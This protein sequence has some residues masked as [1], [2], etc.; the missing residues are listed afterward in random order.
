M[1]DASL[2]S[3][4]NLE[5]LTKAGYTYIVGSRMHKIPY[6]IA[7]YQKTQELTDNQIITTPIE[8][9]QRVIYQYREKR[10]KLDMH[11]IEKQIAKAEKSLAVRLLSRRLSS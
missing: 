11:N 10:A 2:L 5:A 6:D 8:G 7:E 1:A 9:S 3:S 4:K